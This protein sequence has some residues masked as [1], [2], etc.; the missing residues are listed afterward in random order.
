[1]SFAP[2][3]IKV[4]GKAILFGEH[5]VVYGHAAVAMPVQRYLSLRFSPR[6]DDVAR[7]LLI[8][9]AWDLRVDLARP[10]AGS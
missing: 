3:H 4:P 5:A 2:F 10:Q 9:P 8:A 1:V 7:P 6:A